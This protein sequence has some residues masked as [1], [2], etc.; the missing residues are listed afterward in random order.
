V[1]TWPEVTF[2]HARDTELALRGAHAALACGSCHVE[3]VA[4][5]LPAKDC[6]GCHGGD[7]PHGAQLGRNCESCHGEVSW[8]RDVRFDHDLSRFPLLGRHRELVCDD[9]HATPAFQDAGEAC[10]DCHV[11]EDVHM[12]RL[13]ADCALCHAPNDWRNWLFDHDA[14]TAFALDGAHRDLDCL[15][16]HRE[17]VAAASAISLSTSCGGCHR[18]DDVHRGAFGPRCEQCHTTES[19]GS[20]RE[21]R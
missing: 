3:P 8:Q 1:T 20:L 13:G 9:C 6:F 2:D 12:R 5:A 14:Q 17:P 7:D 11:D 10:V 21:G 4:V 18:K 15:G 19:F 16:C